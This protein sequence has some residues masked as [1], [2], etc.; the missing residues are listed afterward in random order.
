[1]AIFSASD[2]RNVSL[3]EAVLAVVPDQRVDFIA[4]LHAAIDMGVF[5]DRGLTTGHWD[6][7]KRRSKTM[8]SQ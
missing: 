5:Y 3:D 1:M 7:G 6:R 2:S 8:N 4:R